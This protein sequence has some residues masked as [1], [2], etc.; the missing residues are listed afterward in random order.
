MRSFIKYMFMIRSLL[1]ILIVFP[2]I[3]NFSFS[4][5]K[6]EQFAISETKGITYDKHYFETENGI[7]SVKIKTIVPIIMGG[8]TTP[9]LNKN[10]LVIQ[11]YRGSDLKESNS[12]DYT[13]PYSNAVFEFAKYYNDRFYI[14]YTA[15]D[16]PRSLEQLFVQEI[17]IGSGRPIGDEKLLISVPEKLVPNP[18]EMSPSPGLVLPAHSEQGKFEIVQSQNNKL[19]MFKYQFKKEKVDGDR[20]DRYGVVLFDNNLN[21]IWSKNDF[22]FPYLSK[23]LDYAD[24]ILS[25]EGEGYLLAKKTNSEAP[26]RGKSKSDPDNFSVSVF[27]ISKDED[28]REINFKLEDRLIKSVT[29]SVLSN[30]DIMC[31]GYYYAPNKSKYTKGLFTSILT[32]NR[33]FKN[34]TYYDFSQEFVERYSGISKSTK[35]SNE[36]K[37][38]RGDFGFQHLKMMDAMNTEDGGLLLIGGLEIPKPSYDMPGRPEMLI[39]TPMPSSGYA[40]GWSNSGIQS[41]IRNPNNIA[42]FGDDIILTKLD[43]RGE[44]M[45][46]QKIPRRTFSR[47]RLL[48]SDRVLYILF[49]D[50]PSN[51]KLKESDAP[52]RL[53]SSPGLLVAHRISLDSGERRVLVIS[54]PKKIEGNSISYTDRWN[55]TN[56]LFPLSNELGFGFQIKTGKK[57]ERIFK[58][59]FEE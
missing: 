57:Q 50:H 35:K 53:E 3:T 6:I 32:R 41:G 4:Q 17:S 1:V 59:I 8:R 58:L 40:Y 20:F 54:K 56:N 26:T 31:T 28:T 46:M 10:K 38:E 7:I 39:E 36:K 52:K 55:L 51:I 25:N 30:G 47:T 2:S 23:H 29:F 19:L 27:I 9:N 14:F 18:K 21:L 43:D 48:F 42:N 34:T 33:E 44:L 12:V 45:W 24:F 11:T 15:F 22:T 49:Q 37:V 5:F 16:Q 13:L